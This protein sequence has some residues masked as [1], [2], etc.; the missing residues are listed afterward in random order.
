MLPL[1]DQDSSLEVIEHFLRRV[2]ISIQVVEMMITMMMS[3]LRHTALLLKTLARVV[4]Q[5]K[6]ITEQMQ[7]H[8]EPTLQRHNNHK[9][10]KVGGQGSGRV[11]QPLR[12]QDQRL[13]ILLDNDRLVN[14]SPNNPW[15]HEVGVWVHKHLKRGGSKEAQVGHLL[16]EPRVQAAQAVQVQ[17][18]HRRGMRVPDLARRAEGEHE[19]CS[20]KAKP[21]EDWQE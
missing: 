9:L 14:N 8:Q 7:V 19:R 3:L 16:D 18:T 12:Q 2:A 15:H 4:I 17:A 21:K 20:L 10:H 1:S 5:A 6:E 13:V 11:Q